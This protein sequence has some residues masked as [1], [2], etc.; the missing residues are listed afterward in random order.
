MNSLIK[1]FDTVKVTTCEFLFIQSY[2][3]NGKIWQ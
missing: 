2:Y 3:N 1:S